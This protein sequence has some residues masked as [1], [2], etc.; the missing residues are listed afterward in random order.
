MRMRLLAVLAGLATATAFGQ[1]DTAWVRRLNGAGDSADLPAALVPNPSGGVWVT[2]HS[3]D[4]DTVEDFLTIRYDGAG[5]AVWLRRYDGRGDTSARATALAADDEG[6]CYVTGKAWQEDGRFDWMTALHDSDGI[7]RWAA[8][9]SGSLAENDEARAVAAYPGG[10]CIVTGAAFGPGGNWD[11][12]TI[13][14]GADGET[15]WVRQLGGSA[16]LGDHAEALA[17]DTAGNIYV[18]GSS[19]GTGTN[20]DILT[21]KY[22]PAGEVLWTERYTGTGGNTEDK[23]TCIAVGPSRDVYVGGYTDGWGT[24]RDF[25]LV[26][27]SADDGETLWTR[28]YNG[29][30]DDYDEVVGVGTSS[31]GRVCVAG[32]SGGI[33]TFADYFVVCYSQAGDSLWA[34]RWDYLGYGNYPVALAVDDDGNSYVTGYGFDPA[35]QYD[36]HTISLGPDGAPRWQIRYSGYANDWDQPVGIGLDADRNVYVTGFS[37]SNSQDFDYVTIKYVQSPGVEETPTAALRQAQFLVRTPTIVRGV[38]FLPVS[39]FTI[40]SSLFDMTGRRVMALQPGA[41]DVSRLAPGIYFL[42]SFD[43]SRLSSFGVQKIIVTR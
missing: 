31:T 30:D 24:S 21:V 10:G 38:L 13:R 41:N 39:P 20:W 19:P 37:M 2:G 40:L 15:L 23:A 35:T 28:R 12:T 36:F 22:S 29:P 25:M 1:I 5:E 4:D 6:N 11:Y 9:H 42:Q 3:F 32:Y 26:R 27:Y 8:Y 18:T 7:V 33:G 16:G 34:F 43:G 17:I 14:Y